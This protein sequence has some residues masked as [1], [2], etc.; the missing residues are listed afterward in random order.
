MHEAPKG[1]QLSDAGALEIDATRAKY[2]TE[3]AQK[4]TTA[5]VSDKKGI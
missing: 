3:S 1:Q 4:A 2:P 5:A